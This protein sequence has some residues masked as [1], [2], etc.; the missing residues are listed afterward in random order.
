MH[1]A[2]PEPVPRRP[3]EHVAPHGAE[4]QRPLRTSIPPMAIGRSERLARRA[5]GF[6]LEESLSIEAAAEL[7]L[8]LA[9]GNA[10]SLRLARA[11]ILAAASDVP[12]ARRAAQALWTALQNAPSPT[13]TSPN[14]PTATRRSA[15]RHQSPRSIV[16]IGPPA[17]FSR[18][19]LAKIPGLDM[20]AATIA[21]YGLSS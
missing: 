4:S 11:R 6:A 5:L 20:P 10:A 7:L 21:A 14:A 15:H 9:G 17:E 8:R 3:D 1:L 12:T 13:A 19:W 16:I 18:R 2:D